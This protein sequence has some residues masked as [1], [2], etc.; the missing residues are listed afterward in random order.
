MNN[1]DLVNALSL[2]PEQI[3]EFIAHREAHKKVV[4]T[5]WRILREVGLA[6]RFEQE[7]EYNDRKRVHKNLADSLEELA[8]KGILRRRAELHGAGYGQEI[9]YDYIGSSE[10]SVS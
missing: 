8:E 4:W 1:N 9:G 3:L 7:L 10:A 2:P 6:T 5:P